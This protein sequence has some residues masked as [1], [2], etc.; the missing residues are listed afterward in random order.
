VSLRTRD[1]PRARIL[2]LEF[3]LALERRRAMNPDFDPRQL[4]APWTLE[5]DTLKVAVNDQDDMKSFNAF[6]D[7]NPGVRQAITDAIRRGSDPGKAVELAM[8]MVAKSAET[9]RPATTGQ[10]PGQAIVPTTLKAAAKIYAD[11]RV[12]LSGNSQGTAGEKRR[13]LDLL[14]TYC[15]EHGRDIEALLVHE[16][17]RGLLIDFVTHYAARDS[18][19][20]AQAKKSAAAK[21]PKKG[22]GASAVVAAKPSRLS[23]RTVMKAV[24]HLADFFTYAAGKQMIVASPMDKAFMDTIDGLRTK[25]TMERSANYSV[26]S[27]ADLRAIFDPKPFLRANSAADD[28][29][30]PLLGLFTG[31]RLGEIVTLTTGAIGVAEGTDVWVM[32]LGTKNENSIRS[33]PVPQSLVDLGFIAYVEH[34]RA[35]GAESIFPHRPLNPTR[36]ADPSKHVS[37]VFGEYLNTLEIRD[38]GKVFHS[39]RHTVITRMHISSV[40]VSDAELI[41]G[42]AAQELV[43][44]REA[45][46][47]HGMPG[48]N[49]TH[50]GTYVH[51]KDD[52][53]PGELLQQRLKRH[54]DN[55]LT[56]AIDMPRLRKAADIVRRHVRTV[57]S[58]SGTF[59]VKS[60]WHTNNRRVADEMVAS[61]GD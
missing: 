56:F 53:L 3:N 8:A 35:M 5:T 45:G 41:V 46:E 32:K 1:L 40:P 22:T 4:I 14:M 59:I 38:P 27:D 19:K 11:S 2:A 9:F 61:L 20:T 51:A 39:L 23:G 7:L 49:S 47:S 50:T 42:H 6:L 24:G 16:V 33:V 15:A 30:A 13:T 60:G 28:F 18:K 12:D 21:T 43:N 54:L 58:R 55:S 26:F 17:S 25:A 57:Q 48:R 52:T 34:V 31:A 29:W 44:R 37:R 36:Q 10:G